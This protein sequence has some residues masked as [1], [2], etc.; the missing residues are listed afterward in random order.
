MTTLL[1]AHGK[2]SHGSLPFLR[3][4]FVRAD[5][6][7]VRLFETL[8]NLPFS[9]AQILR[10]R[11]SDSRPPRAPPVPLLRPR[12]IALAQLIPLHEF[13][14]RAFL[15][16]DTHLLFDAGLINILFYSSDTGLAGDLKDKVSAE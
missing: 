1:A 16:G 6:R 3:R 5:G 7:V 4:C 15:P 10:S 12:H 13:I 14:P 2:L 11:Y 8:G 9:P